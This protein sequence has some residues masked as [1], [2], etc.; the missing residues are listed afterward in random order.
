MTQTITMII[1]AIVAVASLALSIVNYFSKKPHLRI[2]IDNKGYDCFYT[3]ACTKNKSL[4]YISFIHFNIINDS[5]VKITVN[6][7]HLLLNKEILFLTDTQNDYWRSVDFLIKNKDGEFIKSDIYVDYSEPDIKLPLKIEPYD[8]ISVSTIFDFVPNNFSGNIKAKLVF[9][10]AVGTIYKKINLSEYK[11]T[12]LM[13][14][15]DNICKQKR[16]IVDVKK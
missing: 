13:Y 7:I 14:S 16:S 1:T 4:H 12:T 2:N 10:S 8:S 6:N 5:P 3:I 11:Q 9:D 15:M